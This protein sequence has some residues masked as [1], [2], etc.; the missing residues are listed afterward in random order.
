MITSSEDRARI[1][2]DLDAMVESLDSVPAPDGALLVSGRMRFGTS[3][4][5]PPGRLHGGL[6]AYA[7]TLA[8]LDRIPAHDP[9]TTYPVRLDL[10]LYRPLP[11]DESVDFHARYARDERGYELVCD[12]AEREKLRAIATPARDVDPGL[13]WFRSAYERVRSRP[14]LHTIT[15]HRDVPVAVHDE[16][17][18]VEL[19]PAVRGGSPSLA[20][21]V[22]DDGVLGAP[23]VCVALDLLGAVTQGYAWQSRIFTARIDLVLTAASFASERPLLALSDR[24]SEPDAEARVRPAALR[25]GTLVPPTKVRVLLTDETVSEALA[26][27][28]LTLVAAPGELPTPI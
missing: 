28:T 5:G 3:L 24:R 2:A 15:A 6:H 26:Y 13:A 18:A 14:P 1:R 25:D 8:V 10:A 16:L 23:V 20:R 22:G 9:R 19:T 21:F 27:G 17:L 7:R 11:L 4:V 12:H